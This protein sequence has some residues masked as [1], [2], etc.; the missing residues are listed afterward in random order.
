M[1]EEMKHIELKPQNVDRVSKKTSHLS[2]QEDMQKKLDDKIKE[3]E[4][5]LNN[6]ES[7]ANALENEATE[8]LKLGDKQAAK[9][10]LI[11]QKK[12]FFRKNISNLIENNVIKQNIYHFTF[13]CLLYM[14]RI[15]RNMYQN[16]TSGEKYY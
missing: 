1:T 10:L 15:I 6:L 13:M 8:K 9:S 11:K 12:T 2:A 5:K 4:L 14:H 3:Q 16:V 7:E